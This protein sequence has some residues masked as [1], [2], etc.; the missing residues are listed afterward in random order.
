MFI[1]KLK[2]VFAKHL[3]VSYGGWGSNFQSVVAEKDPNF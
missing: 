1:L 3:S 2:N